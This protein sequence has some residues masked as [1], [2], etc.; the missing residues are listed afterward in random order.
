MHRR[1]LLS[2]VGSAVFLAG[3]LN[4]QT[5]S[6]DDHTSV[7]DR[8]DGA[9]DRPECDRESKTVEDQRTGA[10]YETEETIPYPDPPASTDESTV[11]EYVDA[12]E[13]AHTT[14]SILCEVFSDEG[15]IELA[16]NTVEHETFDWY[17]TIHIIFLVRERGAAHYVT[18]DGHS[19]MAD[20]GT[21]G[22]AYAVDETGAARVRTPS[23]FTPEAYEA[24]G[25]DPLEEGKL[26]DS[27]D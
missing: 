18:E 6:L 11:V 4:D 3:C 13:T 19:E 22:V 27:F 12:F 24:E 23:V 14:H 21:T 26:V 7:R 2:V 15:V 9:P 1:A 16:N 20:I 17:D 10:I 5:T 8:F 25:P